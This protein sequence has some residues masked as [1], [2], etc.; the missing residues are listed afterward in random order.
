[1]QWAKNTRDAELALQDLKMTEQYSVLRG[2]IE[3]SSAEY[4]NH[5]EVSTGSLL[6][7]MEHTV[8]DVGEARNAKCSDKLMSD[9][10]TYGGNMGLS[11]RT[12]ARAALRKVGG[13]IPSIHQEP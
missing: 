5:F 13:L 10:Y 3:G 11:I 9:F 12:V 2:I 1:M 6:V 7:Q 8:A 4:L